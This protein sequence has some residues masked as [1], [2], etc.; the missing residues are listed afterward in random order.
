M[1]REVREWFPNNSGVLLQIPRGPAPPQTQAPDHRT[2]N[3][4]KQV[5]NS[6]WL[7]AQAPWITTVPAWAGKSWEARVPKDRPAVASR[8]L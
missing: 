1:G 4:G 5:E 6:L 2:D 7:S 3:T 8:P